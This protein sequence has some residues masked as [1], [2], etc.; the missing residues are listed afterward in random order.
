MERF[1]RTGEAV[2]ERAVLS[3]VIAHAREAA[4]GAILWGGYAEPRRLYEGASL[5]DGPEVKVRDQHLGIDFW[6]EAGTPVHAVAN[7]VLH[8]QQDNARL[9]DYGPTI[10]LRHADGLHS[11]YGHLSRASLRLHSVPGE[12]IPAGTL[13]GW[14]GMP[15]ENVDWPPHLHFQLIHDMQGLQGDYPGVCAMPDLPFYLANCPDPAP[16]F[17]L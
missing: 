13:L 2:W 14:M 6:A 3:G 5:F 10:I 16:Y 1:S 11:L 7:A 8:S 4:G 15:E 9:R 12:A 17:G